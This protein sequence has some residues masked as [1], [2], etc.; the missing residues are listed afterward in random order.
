MARARYN[1][2]VHKLLF[3][4]YTI[5]MKTRNMC[6]CINVNARAYKVNRTEAECVSIENPYEASA[7]ICF[8]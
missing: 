7:V 8:H 4:T 2:Y 3:Y 5:Q 6:V 1:N